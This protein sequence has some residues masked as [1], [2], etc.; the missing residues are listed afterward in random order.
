M[1]NQSTSQSI[2][3]IKSNEIKSINQSINQSS[4]QSADMAHKNR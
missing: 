2:N 4:S 1:I 3:Q